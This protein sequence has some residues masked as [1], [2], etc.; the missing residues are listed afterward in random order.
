MRK[1]RSC[2]GA[3]ENNPHIVVA[4]AGA[5]GCFVGGLLA[6]GGDRVSLLMRPRMAQEIRAHGLTLTDFSGM[7]Q[8]INPDEIHLTADPT[9]LSTADI[10]LVTVQSG[11]TAAIGRT[12]AALAPANAIIISLQNATTNAETLARILPDHDIRGGMVPFNVIPLGQ[13]CF[14]RATGGD[15]VIATGAGGLGDT[16]TVPHL[17]VDETPEIAAVLW[18]KFLV[19]LNNALNALSGLTLQE[20]LAQPAWRRLMADQWAEA[21]GVLRAKGIPV[22]STTS[23]PIWAVPA[24]LRLPTA[25]FRRVAASMLQMDA[26]ARSSMSHDL[27]AGRPTDIDALQGQVLRMAADLGRAVPVT[28]MVYDVLQSAELAGEGLPNLPAAALRREIG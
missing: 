16:L 27:M 7:A 21:L 1:S 3:L 11:D 12:I 5:I 4:G 10:V 20:Q 9:I 24:I 8:Q 26:Q 6:A 17:T 18:G 25:V 28:A 15:L 19:N 22:V 2:A 23:A 13:G 14:H